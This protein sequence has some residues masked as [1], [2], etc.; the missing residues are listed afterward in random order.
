MHPPFG[1]KAKPPEAAIK[2]Q[3]P[4]PGDQADRRCGSAAHHE[5]RPKCWNDRQNIPCRRN[6]TSGLGGKP[7]R[8]PDINADDHPVRQ[9]D[10][11]IDKAPAQIIDRPLLQRRVQHSQ[12]T[13]GETAESQQVQ[14]SGRAGMA[15]MATRQSFYDAL[16]AC[17]GA[18]GC[19]DGAK[20]AFCQASMCSSV[21]RLSRADRLKDIGI[22]LD[23]IRIGFTQAHLKRV[24]GGIPISSKS[25]F[26]AQRKTPS[27]TGALVEQ[28]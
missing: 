19:S 27:I 4:K 9:L 20:T 21:S 11:W 8:T 5:E 13:P 28:G 10:K 17:F 24:S 26:P 23:I 3:Q 22:N 15:F 14:G 12:G 16:G 2:Q 7:Q 25:D 18:L 6:L 1:R